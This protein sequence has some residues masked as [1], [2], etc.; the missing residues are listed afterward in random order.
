MCY[1]YVNLY[2]KILKPRAILFEFATDQ[3]ASNPKDTVFQCVIEKTR[4]PT[5][6][7]NNKITWHI[8]TFQCTKNPLDIQNHHFY[9]NL[10]AKK[11]WK[12]GTFSR[13]TF[14]TFSLM[15]RR[16]R[17]YRYKFEIKFNFKQN[18]KIFFST[19]SLK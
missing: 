12:T 13:F 8:R 6:N 15:M 5:T 14:I 7:N 11:N 17:I 3:R 9:S 19:S 18:I 4:K 16:V 10:S 1:I 2:N